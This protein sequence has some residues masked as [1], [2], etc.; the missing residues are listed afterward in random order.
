MMMMDIARDGFSTSFLNSSHVVQNLPEL[1]LE[2]HYIDPVASNDPEIQKVRRN[3]F[4]FNENFSSLS[5][6]SVVTNVT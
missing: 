2:V 6:R 5:V 3:I 1:D 4:E